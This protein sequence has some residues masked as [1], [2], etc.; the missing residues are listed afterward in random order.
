MTVM[1][2]CVWKLVSYVIVPVISYLPWAGHV[3]PSP[4]HDLVPFLPTSCGAQGVI[5]GKGCGR[6]GSWFCPAVAEEVSY[7]AHWKACRGQVQVL[8]SQDIY[9][10][11]LTVRELSW[12]LTHLLEKVVC[13]RIELSFMEYPH[14]PG[15][16]L[17]G[18]CMLFHL[19]ARECYEIL[20]NYQCFHIH[21]TGTVQALRSL[22]SQSNLKAWIIPFSN[23]FCLLLL[24][25]WV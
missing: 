16:L 11:L 19:F 24:R 14:V 23:S 6:Q 18:F 25:L 4:L 8:F 9:N 3:P 10:G 7:L 1:G 21:L 22:G 2:H 20:E 15:T 17:S 12:Q 5:P 13:I